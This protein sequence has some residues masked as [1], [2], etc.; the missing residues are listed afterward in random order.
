VVTTLVLA[1]TAGTSTAAV[2]SLV[3]AG[4]AGVGRVASDPSA[5]DPTII[6][7]GRY[8][9]SISTGS[10]LPVSRSADLLHW[11]QL[12]PVF[13]E[14]PSWVAREL[15]FTPAD[16]WA[17]DLTFFDGEYHLYYA[18]SSFGR[19][20]SVIGLATARTLDPDS[21]A[22]GWVDRGMVLRSRT[23]DNFNAIDP[24][25]A[26]DTGGRAWL[27][28]GSFWDGIKMRRLDPNTGMPAADDQTLYSLA[29][30][31]GASIEASSIARH[32][33][34]YYLFT[35]L[36]Y[37]CRGTNSDYRVVVGRSTDITGPY[38]DRDG[39]ALLAGGGTELLRG[40]NEFRGPG[41]GDV[42]SAGGRDWF[43]HHYYDASDAGR[44]KQSVRQISWPDGWPSLDD[45]LSGSSRVGRG[46]AYFTVVN[47]ANAGAIDNPTCGYEGADIR[48]GVPSD[49][50]CQ[51]WRLDDSGDGYASI[52]NRHSNKVA[53]VAACI[54]TDGA[55][56]AQWGWLNNDCQK[57]RL[58]PTDNGWSRIENKLAG[59]VLETAG[60]GGIGTA[61][62]TYTWLGNACQ[63]FR[64]D[65]VGNLLLA[66]TSGRHVLDVTGCGNTHASRLKV[67]AP[68]R[69]SGCQL[70]QFTH[71][72]DGYYQIVNQRYGKP[73][74]VITTS[75]GA[76]RLA[77]GAIGELS[78]ASQWRIEA[79]ND[80]GYRLVNRDGLAADLAHPAS[81]GTPGTSPTQRLLLVV[82]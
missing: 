19:N 2:A 56:V 36:D 28:F 72:V 58:L 25:V 50:P 22:Y 73:I 37:C 38:L 65:P 61:V 68:E 9:Y 13:A 53:E 63:Q 62:Q 8:Y 40:Y 7:Q 18:A 71:T 54:N 82:P 6:K 27:S 4:T 51:Q 15:G 5:H 16:L 80:G 39:V 3:T 44:P 55:R 77:L 24:N 49:S 20:E 78:A 75:N 41:G 26:F 23:T 60:C 67:G 29:S 74:T 59:R 47:R 42:F 33:G 70:W 66:D 21:A 48:I 30:R 35:S 34:Y 52:L 69:H 14:P 81:A 43:V 46:G 64:L 45:P 10:F 31:G 17:P 12:A 76:P 32:G 57:F 11:A 79:L 1:L